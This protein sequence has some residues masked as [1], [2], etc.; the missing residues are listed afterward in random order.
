MN[1]DH[2]LRQAEIELEKIYAAIGYHNCMFNSKMRTKVFEA[3]VIDNSQITNSTTTE[4]L[5]DILIDC[6]KRR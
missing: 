2:G 5:I 3:N 4:E 6:L 1:E